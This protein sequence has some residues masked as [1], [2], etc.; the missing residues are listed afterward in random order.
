MPLNK[1]EPVVIVPYDPCWPLEFKNLAEVLKNHL[2]ELAI[3][4]EH[5]G[6]TSVPGLP[7]KPIID[8][9]VVIAGE[10]KLQEV[11]EQLKTLD[12]TPEGEKG[13]PGRWAFSRKDEKTPND[14][15]QKTWMDHHLYVCPEGTLELKRH[16]FL[17][18]Y[19]RFHPETARAYGKMKKVFSEE[20]AQDRMEYTE[21]KTD[22]LQKILARG[23]PDYELEK[24]RK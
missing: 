19:L 10:E 17:R 23:A 12:Y 3:A 7:A 15:S 24:A 2:G 16:L 5:V 20:F 14:G 22:F 18:E 11:T 4:I 13:I 21:A 8:L 9:D 1:R 6:S